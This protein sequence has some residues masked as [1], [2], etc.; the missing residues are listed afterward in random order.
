LALL[1][2][3]ASIVVVPDTNSQ[4]QAPIKTELVWSRPGDQILTPGFSPDGNFLVVVT[5]AYWPDGGDAE[6][7]PE[8]FLKKLAAKAKGN[9]RFADPVIKVIDLSGNVVCEVRYGW[10]PSLSR[11]DKRIVF[12]EQVKPISGFR[13]LASPQAGNAIR[14]YDCGTK[15][16]TKIADPNIGY[17]DAPFFS[18]DG[19]SIGLYRK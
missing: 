11:D 8:S 1:F 12:S 5:R 9:P 13:E 4:S 19:E 10:N 3:T 18:P 14:L 16:L 7:L 15:E 17:F 6:G 2:L